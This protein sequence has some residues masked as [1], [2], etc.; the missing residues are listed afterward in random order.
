MSTAG[1]RACSDSD[2]SSEMLASRC[3]NVVTIPG[4]VYSS[5]GTYTAWKEVIEP[6]TVDAM[7]SSRSPISVDRVGWYPTAEGILPSSA[8]T[9]MPARDV[10]VDVVDEQEYVLFLFVPEVLGHRQ[11]GER[12]ACARAGRLVH[13]AKHERGRT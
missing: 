12:D 9:S 13:L 11:A 3:P 6:F 5:A 2:R 10:A 7:R 1:Y 8:D 4:S